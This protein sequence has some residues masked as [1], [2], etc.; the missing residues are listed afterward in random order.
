MKGQLIMSSYTFHYNKVR[1]HLHT[2]S[3]RLVSIVTVLI[4]Q[5]FERKVRLTTQ[6][7]SLNLSSTHLKQPKKDINSPIRSRTQCRQ[8]QANDHTK[9]KYSQCSN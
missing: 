1:T 5:I 3:Q 2:S 8:K 9:Y 7:Y 6:D 4:E